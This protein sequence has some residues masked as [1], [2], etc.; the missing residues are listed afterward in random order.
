MARVI[1]MSG[2][3]RS[4][5][6]R[7]AETRAMA[8]AERENCTLHY[9]ACGQATDPEMKARIEHHQQDRANA[10][11]PWETME[12]P[13]NIGSV[14]AQ[15]NANAVVLLDC[16]TTLLSNALFQDVDWADVTE[17]ERIQ[18]KIKEDISAVS[19]N[20][21]TLIIVSNELGHEPLRSDL[22]RVYARL[23]GEL[24]QWIVE[25][26]DEA[27]LVEAGIPQFLKGEAI[28]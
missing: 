25:R 21:H 20:C 2:G 7:L 4:G 14:A 13:T 23:L 1:F 28:E 17:Q 22:I 27:I 19:E 15:L 3:V 9:I 26:A 5:K 10:N 8:E 6:S 16:V 11:V 24:H 12:C 18:T